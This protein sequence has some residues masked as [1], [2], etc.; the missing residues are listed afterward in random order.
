MLLGRYVFLGT[1]L[2]MCCCF[3]CLIG[4]MVAT[5]ADLLSEEDADTIRDSLEPRGML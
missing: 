4:A 1:T 5:E 2:M 3:C